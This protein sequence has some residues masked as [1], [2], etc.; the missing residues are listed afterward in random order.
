MVYSSGLSTLRDLVIFQTPRQKREKGSRVEPQTPDASCRLVCKRDEHIV[1][2]HP[3]FPEYENA[4]RKSRER[5][6]ER[7]KR[8]PPIQSGHMKSS[9][10]D[11]N[12]VSIF[13]LLRAP[14]TE[15]NESRGRGT[16][17]S[18]SPSP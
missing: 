17:H 5:E 3:A 15:P 18:S 6:R 8:A 13:I 14:K 10:L 4:F 7:E 1:D 11:N 2:I 16:T 12:V 9:S